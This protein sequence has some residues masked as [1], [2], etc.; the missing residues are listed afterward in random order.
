MKTGTVTFPQ[1]PAEVHAM[2]LNDY[3]YSEGLFL[4]MSDKQVKWTVTASDGEKRELKA[5]Y[6]GVFLGFFQL[7][8]SKG[9]VKF[10]GLKN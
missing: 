5:T 1:S 10:N 8:I 4:G 6:F 3:F 7:S 9:K 2:Q